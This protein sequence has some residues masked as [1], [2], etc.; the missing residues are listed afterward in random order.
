MAR[1]FQIK[2][3][4]LDPSIAYELTPRSVD[5]TGATVVF[6]MKDSMDAIK[7]NRG[8][9]S[10]VTATGTPTVKYDWASGDTDTIGTYYGEFEVTYASGKPGTFPNGEDDFIEIVIGEDIA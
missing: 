1:K 9:G 6:N 3:N 10:I 8:A 5:L 2:R 4:D 7:V